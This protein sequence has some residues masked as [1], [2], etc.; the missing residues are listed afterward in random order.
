MLKNYNIIIDYEKKEIK[1]LQEGHEILVRYT[2]EDF[3]KLVKPLIDD[4]EK[5]LRYFEWDS[6]NLSKEK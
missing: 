1:F 5:T 2:E 6:L 3:E 4:L